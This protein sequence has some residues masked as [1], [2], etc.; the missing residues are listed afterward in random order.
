[1]NHRFTRLLNVLLLILMTIPVMPTS[2]SPAQPPIPPSKDILIRLRGATFDPLAGEPELPAGLRAPAAAGP[3]TYLLQFIGPVQKEWKDTLQKAGIRLYDY[4]PDYAFIARMDAATAQAAQNLAFVRWVGAYHPAYRLAPTLPKTR[5]ATPIIVNV[6]TLPDFD[7]KKLSAPKVLADVCQGKSWRTFAREAEV[8]R[9]TTN[10]AAGFLR[11]H[12]PSGQLEAL[13]ALDGI[14]WIEPYFEHELYND[15]GGGQI[16]RA[17]AVRADLGLYG[18]GQ[19]VAVADTGLDTGDTSTLHPDVRDRLVQAY[20]LGRTGD[21]SDYGAHGTHVAGSVLGN[22][23]AS[24]SNNYA[25]TAPEAQLVF[26]SVADA[27]GGLSGIP[28]DEGD[29][30]RTAYS[31]GARIHTNSWG[32]PTGGTYQ[33]PEYG[34]YVVPSRN[35]DQAMWEHQDMLVLFAAGNQG[36]DANQDGLIELDSIGQPGTA[37]NVLTVGASENNRSSINGTWGDS[38]GTPIAEDK[39]ADNPDGMAAFSSR[40]PTDDG[41]IKPD[42]VAPGTHVAS[43][44]TR[45]YVF[46]DDMEDDTSGYSSVTLNGGTGNTWQLATDDPHSP[47]RY[48][49]NTVSGSY[50]PNAMTILLTPP[51]NVALAGST[52]DV[53]FWHKYTLGSQDRLVL[54][55]ADNA[56]HYVWFP[57]NFSGTQSVYTLQ[58][59]MMGVGTLVYYGVD[60]TNVQ[61]GFAITSEDTTYDSSWW[62]DDVRVNASGWGAMSDV[63]LAQPGDTID[64]A[65]MMMGG[66]SMATPL[67]AGASALVREWLTHIQG[68]SAPSA[69]LIKALL[70]NGAAD[71]SPGQYSHPQ[72]VPSYRPNYVTG[73]GRIDLV[74]SLNPPVPR[75]VWFTETVQGLNTGGAAVYQLVVGPSSQRQVHST[76]KAPPVTRTAPP[77]RPPLPTPDSARSFAN[78]GIMVLTCPGQCQGADTTQLLQNADFDSGGWSPWQTIGWPE[79][80]DQAYHSAPYSAWLAGYDDAT[81]FIYQQVDIPTGAQSASLDF[82]YMVYSEETMIGNDY[83]CYDITDTGINSLIG[84][85]YCDDLYDTQQEQWLQV[86]HTLTGEDLTPLLGQ[87]VLVWFFAQTDSTDFSSVWVDDTALN[88]TT[89][90]SVSPVLTV[91]PDS[92]T[93]GTSFAVNGTGFH[94]GSAVDL[95]L[96]GSPAGTAT[97]DESGAFN[98]TLNTDGNITTGAHTV[99]ATDAQGAS[100][101]VTFNISGDSETGGPLRVTLA[102]TD[103]PGSTT[104]AKALVNDLDLEVITPKGV[105]YYGNQDL[106]INGGDPYSCRRGGQ[107]DQCNNVEGII[108]PDAPYGTYTIKVSAYNVGQGP[109]PFAL[110]ASGDNLGGSSGPT[111]TY[112]HLVYLPLVLRGR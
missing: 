27:N 80:T 26:Q 11:L 55:V 61:I 95:T 78:N 72:E 86:Q 6:Q 84:G 68:I 3:G 81:D 21:W 77:S 92:G 108:I 112:D 110:V 87:T 53:Q 5:D 29:L 97:T 12:L 103:Y 2:A 25:G 33:A 43:L 67:T 57:L 34:G 91:T 99:Q 7:L 58:S 93:P 85:S 79:L 28:I 41:R 82:W 38:Y 47:T 104:A 76:H 44:R 18:A 96:D 39:I 32:G 73:W 24:G 111:P 63:G 106:Y 69:A 94:T 54:F 83:F 42:V 9:H 70:I 74:E 56:N 65:Y 17:D 1:M 48:W 90:S 89:G 40:G 22:G 75:S 45:Q 105:H 101:S 15:V 51:M 10:A 64:E 88:V 16:M 23:T 19:I 59:I 62:L 102:W 107:W 4:I 60:P 98:Y 36:V 50:T 52:F 14:L 30:M 13:A 46:D 71:M 66:T 49:K 8:Q 100:A 20:A 31:D 35:V 109:Q 37:K